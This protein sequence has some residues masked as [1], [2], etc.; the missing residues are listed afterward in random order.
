MKQAKELYNALRD[1]LNTGEDI[2]PAI[3]TA[4]DKNLFTCDVVFDTIELGGI[5]LQS[6][7]KA[8]IKGV[9][10]FPA[11]GSVVLVKRINDTEYLVNMY[12][13]VESV[14]M[15]V[16]DKTYTLNNEGHL[17]AGTNGTD[18]LLQ[19]ITL[20]IEAVT[21]IAVLYGNNPDYAKLSQ[22]LEKVNNI[23]Q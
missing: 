21:Q 22:A 14:V 8:G 11:V 18:T 6:I 10:V 3:V 7:V 19:V 5:R 12:S 15:Q 13:D 23:L 4:V 16:A 2:F 17:I 1:V 20:V 9:Q